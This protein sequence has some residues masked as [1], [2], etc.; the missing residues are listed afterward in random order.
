MTAAD[1][2]VTVRL[3]YKEM[4]PDR[5]QH[6]SIDGPQLV[7]PLRSQI[8]FEYRGPGRLRIALMHNVTHFDYY[9]SIIIKENEIYL[10]YN[11]FLSQS[12]A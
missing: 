8:K 6:M 3:W 9:I 7:I 2:F 1:W 4:T 10:R 12:P 11:R 5:N